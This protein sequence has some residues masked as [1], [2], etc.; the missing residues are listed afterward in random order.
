MKKYFCILISSFSLLFFSLNSFGTTYY[1]IANTGWATPS[2]W[3]QIGCGG[4][5][6]ITA[7]GAGDDVIICA[8][9]TVIMNGSSV[10]CNSLTI[11]GVANWAAALTTNVGAGGITINSGG[12]ITG[13]VA[14]ILTTTG[15][16]T[17]NST[18]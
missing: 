1:S 18:L 15:G 7:P 5:A 3:S 14:G 12:N 11:N 9:T 8:G 10:N 17:L 4:A 6:S 16:L 13:A 2:T